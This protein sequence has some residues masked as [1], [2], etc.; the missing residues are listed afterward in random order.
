[1]NKLPKEKRDRIVLMGLLTVIVMAGVWFSLITGQQKQLAVISRQTEDQRDQV[2]K[3]E[4]LIKSKPKVQADL[5][6]VADELKSK[7]D[8]MAAGDLFSWFYNRLNN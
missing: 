2:D 6:A 3:A 5:Q 7:E 4:R 1:M 8:D